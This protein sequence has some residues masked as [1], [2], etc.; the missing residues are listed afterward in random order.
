MFCVAVLAVVGAVAGCGG[1]SS[2]TKTPPPP[3]SDAG[4]YSVTVTGT[5]NGIVHSAK[6]TVVVP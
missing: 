5:A 1:G 6:I 4:T 2:G 3:P